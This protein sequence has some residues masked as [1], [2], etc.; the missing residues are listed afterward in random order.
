M[1]TALA[2]PGY[3]TYL[4]GRSMSVRAPELLDA[5]VLGTTT[6]TRVRYA[7]DGTISGP[8][9]RVVDAEKLTWVIETTYDRTTHRGT[10][11]VVPDHYHGLLRCRGTLA[12]EESDGATVETVAGRLEVRVPLLSGAAEKAVFGGFTRHLA[13]EAEAL[14][15]YCAAR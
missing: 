12:F 13:I 1:L 6:T 11:V 8:A 9:A 10:V 5:D 7:F 15:G 4:G 2:D 3:Y 14:A